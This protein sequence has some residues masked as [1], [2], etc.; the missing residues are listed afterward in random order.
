MTFKNVIDDSI[1]SSISGAT[2]KTTSP[3]KA[4]L[5]TCMSRQQGK[6]SSRDSN[7]SQQCIYRL[8]VIIISPILT[9]SPSIR[10][11]NATGLYGWCSLGVRNDLNQQTGLNSTQD[12]HSAYCF[13]PRSTT[14]MCLND[15]AHV[16]KC[17]GSC[18]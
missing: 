8:R 15:Q 10:S 18:T 2:A 5:A 6:L 11:Q 13:H 9:L 1:S 3:E 14:S 17:S 7:S 12:L 16:P 4:V